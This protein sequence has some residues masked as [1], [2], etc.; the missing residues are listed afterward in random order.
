MTDN[1]SIALTDEQKDAK[2]AEL[3]QE[4]ADMEQWHGGGTYLHHSPNPLSLE[5]VQQLRAIRQLV[6]PWALRESQ[7]VAGGKPFVSHDWVRYALDTIFGAQNWSVG[8]GE[9]EAKKVENG[10][11]IIVISG[12]ITVRWADGTESTR[13]DIGVAAIRMERDAKDRNE[14]DL[15]STKTDAYITALKAA[16]TSAWK[17]CA[18]D[19]GNVFS[20]IQDSRLQGDIMNAT[21]EGTIKRMFDETPLVERK[22]QKKI[23]KPRG[24]GELPTH[25]GEWIGWKQEENISVGMVKSAL[26]GQT[27]KEWVTTGKGTWEEA[28]EKVLAYLG[29]RTEELPA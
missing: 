27:G 12:S 7:Y 25:S 6:P 11:M 8:L 22:K 23:E 4:L 28:A 14:T 21:F 1:T 24:N 2:I 16:A 15:R 20:P 29:K 10:E 18:R 13:S 5:V 17:G 9:H 3:E 26:G 19:L